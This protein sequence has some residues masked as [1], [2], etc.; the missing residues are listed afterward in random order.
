MKKSFIAG[1]LLLTAQKNFAAIKKD[2]AL[3][4]LRKPVT[5]AVI[6][7]GTDI[8]HKELK[9]YIWTN[10]GETGTDRWGR[11]KSTNGIDDDGNGYADDLHGWNFVSN[12]NDLLDSMGHG[13]HISGIIK[14]ESS[15][16][17]FQNNKPKIRLMILK[18]YDAESSDSQNIE[19]T[20]KA[21]H[22]AI[23]MGAQVINYSGGGS[24]PSRAELSALQEANRRHI[25]VVAAA[26]NNN[27]NTDI[28]GYYPANYRLPNIISVAATDKTGELMSFSNYGQNSIDLAA[29][30]Q[31]VF[32][33]MPGNKFG[34]MSGTSQSTAF[35]TGALALKLWE[36]GS[37][38]N[39]EKGWLALLKE[40]KFNKSLVG[41]TR[42]QMALLSSAN[43]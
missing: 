13:T 16:S 18:Y 3:P 6:D 22:Y 8:N 26:G 4:D 9:N 37:A 20:V 1:I 24:L 19:N 40:A 11:D 27:K 35:V 38:E 14:N 7:T 32:S 33:T 28:M 41:K 25:F 36:T 10:P 23:K 43:P 21:M 2:Q 31:Q 39:P 17:P 34:F 12:T 29:P 30:G 5:V 42:F 15:K